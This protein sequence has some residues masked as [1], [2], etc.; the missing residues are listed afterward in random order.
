MAAALLS[1]GAQERQLVCAA[2]S[3]TAGLFWFISL[4]AE[5][6]LARRWDKRM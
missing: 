2:M 5:W 6:L 4:L 3:V 1:E